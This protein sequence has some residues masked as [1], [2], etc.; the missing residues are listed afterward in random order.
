MKYSEAFERDYDFYMSM[1]N[2]MDFDGSLNKVIESDT[3]G[4]SAKEAFYLFDSQGKTVPTSEPKLLSKLFKT[5]GSVNFHIKM[6]AQGR[7]DMTMVKEE[8]DN[9]CTEFNAP[10]WFKEAVEN[11]KYKYGMRN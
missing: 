2:I 10:D 5:K 9:I 11:Q 6:Y 3:L 7:A 1:L 8:L 4:R